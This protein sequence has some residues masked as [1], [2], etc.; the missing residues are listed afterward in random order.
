[1]PDSQKEVLDA[2]SSEKEFLALCEK[3]FFC[4]VTGIIDVQKFIGS[5]NVLFHRGGGGRGVA[6]DAKIL[7]KRCTF[8][9]DRQPHKHWCSCWITRATGPHNKIFQP[10][11]TPAGYKFRVSC[12]LFDV[13]RPK[14]PLSTLRMERF[15]RNVAAGKPKG[16]SAAAAGYSPRCAKTLASA[17]LRDPRVRERIEFLRTE[18][19]RVGSCSRAELKNG[20]A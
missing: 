11:I 15:A 16:K 7:K 20:S 3:A 10:T 19:G 13:N 1:M 14:E 18:S 12:T 4:K 17:L 8:T 2:N 5:F 6:L 9:S